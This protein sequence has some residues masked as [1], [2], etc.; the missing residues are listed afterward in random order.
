M[1]H[2]F[3]VTSDSGSIAA[4]SDYPN[5]VFQ[6]IFAPITRSGNVNT[7]T[8]ISK[9]YPIIFMLLGVG[10]S[11]S[12]LSVISNGA[13]SWQ[14]KCICSDY[15]NIYV[16]CQMTGTPSGYGM[17]VWNSDGLLCFDSSQNPL[18]AE[19]VLSLNEGDS[20]S[21]KGDLVSFTGGHAFPQSSY[22]DTEVHVG[23]YVFI[24]YRFVNT[25]VCK[26]E[27]VCRWVT[28]GGWENVCTSQ[29]T[30]STDYMGNNSCGYQTVCRSEWV[31]RSSNVCGYETVCNWE[32]VNTPFWVTTSVSAMVRTTNWTIHRGTAVRN[33]DGYAFKWDL[34]DSG[35]Y[36]QVL[37]TYWFNSATPT[38]PNSG[39]PTGYNVPSSFY[40]TNE[41]VSGPFTKN[42]TFPYASTKYNMINSTIITARSNDYA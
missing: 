41:A 18:N 39:T 3:I 25:Y 31:T 13:N 15:I 29:Y 34:H 20:I 35:Y 36:K 37:N 27:Y 30:C 6:G 10:S 33:S 7:Y 19:K 32:N 21:A 11:G 2:G 40:T 22:Y 8:V 16:F 4:N 9:K 12:V 14:I 1:S 23:T 28:T 42:N 26:S 5:F 24:E 38:S 17:A